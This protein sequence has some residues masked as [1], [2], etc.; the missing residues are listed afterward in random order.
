MFGTMGA[1]E[2]LSIGLDAMTDNAASAMRA[3]RSGRM[4]STFEGVKRMLLPFE[5]YSKGFLVFVAADFAWSHGIISISRPRVLRWVNYYGR[6]LLRRTSF[7]PSASLGTRGPRPIERAVQSND[8][9]S[10]ALA[11]GVLSATSRAVSRPL[12]V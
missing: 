12:D 2:D 4:N 6:P 5:R 11:L 3:L 1:A 9:R 8:D 7:V 10:R